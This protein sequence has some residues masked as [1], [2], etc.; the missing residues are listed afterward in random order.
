MAHG[1]RDPKRL[2]TEDSA[3]FGFSWVGRACKWLR[4]VD[5]NHRPLGYEFEQKLK[6]NELAGVVAY[7]KQ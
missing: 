1:S 7:F 3:Y 5:L 2:L 4:G 6:F